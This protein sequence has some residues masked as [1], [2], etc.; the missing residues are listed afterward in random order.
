MSNKKLIGYSEDKQIAEYI[1]MFAK[2]RGLKT[3][4]MI[5]Q[6]LYEYLRRKLPKIVLTEM[7]NKIS[8]LVNGH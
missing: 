4:A 3:S 7:H 8:L 1:D 5:R 6:A 2:T